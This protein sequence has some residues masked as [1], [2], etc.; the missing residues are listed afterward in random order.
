MKNENPRRRTMNQTMNQAAHRAGHD[1]NRSV[2][3]LKSLPEEIREHAPLWPQRIRQFLI[4]DTH[5]AAR[6]IRRVG[7]ERV[8]RLKGYTT[9]AKINRKRQAERQQRFLRQLLIIVM[10]ILLI[11]LL[12]N[13]YNPFRDLSEWS[14]IVGVRSLNEMVVN[15]NETSQSESTAVSD[16]TMADENVTDESDAS[17]ADVAE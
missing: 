13:L 12:F 17:A 1:I 4:R 5:Q 6:S 8:F 11:I 10:T 2:R 16:E 9:V 15:L 3:D 14:R 7:K